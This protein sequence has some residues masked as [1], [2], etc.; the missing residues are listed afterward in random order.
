MK[1]K[2][3]QAILFKPELR[4]LGGGKRWSTLVFLTLIYAFAL[5]SL[6]AGQQIQKFLYKKM[7]DPYVKLLVAKIPSSSCK[8]QIVIDEIL[9]NTSFKK[10]FKLD[11]AL[12]MA[13]GYLNFRGNN[14]TEISLKFGEYDNKNHPLW[15]MLKNDTSLFLTSATRCDPFNDFQQSGVILSEYAATELEVWP[16]KENTYPNITW[17]RTSGGG[18]EEV[19]LPILAVMESLPMDLDVTMH[20]K[21]LMQLTSG[22]DPKTNDYF[23]L[24][25]QTIKSNPDQVLPKKSNIHGGGIFSNM[26]MGDVYRF[27]DERGKKIK[28]LDLSN[29]KGKLS[30]EYLLFKAGDLGKVRDLA[31]ELAKN[32]KTYGCSSADAGTLEIDL[33]EVESKENLG[34]FSR[35]AFL[36]SAAL[37]VIALILI[38]NY[39]GAILRLHINKNKR[40][41]GTLTAFGYENSTITLLYLLITATILGLSFAISYAL[42]WTIGYFGFTKFLELSNLSDV[43]VSFAHIPLYFSVPLFVLLPLIIVSYRIRKQLKATPGDLVY[44]R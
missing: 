6:G 44:D 34:I 26:A 5:F 14:K 42:V 41:L 1:R 30:K 21:T 11:S 28:L 7:E 2:T 18:T 4:S 35:F 29:V 15:S 36:L 20:E 24:S 8:K 31:N 13:K 33:T 25:D 9:R 16:L 27:L 39:T 19:E 22:N 10:K 17:T 38:I 43:D 40:N 37:V 3:L 12:T 32:K 23:F